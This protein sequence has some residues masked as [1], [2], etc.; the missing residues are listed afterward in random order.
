MV[1][2]G[3]PQTY[4]LGAMVACGL[5]GAFW[6]MRGVWSKYNKKVAIDKDGNLVI[7][8]DVDLA[9]TACYTPSKAYNELH[10]LSTNTSILD[11]HTTS[12]LLEQFLAAPKNLPKA[13]RLTNISLATIPKILGQTANS[14]H[15][16]LEN[17]SYPVHL[18]Q[19]ETSKNSSLTPPTPSIPTDSFLT[20]LLSIAPKITSL[21]ITGGNIQIEK[22]EIKRNPI[23]LQELCVSETSHE[24]V[25]LLLLDNAIQVD[26]L[27]I[28]NNN[29]T[30]LRF[31]DTPTLYTLT[32]LSIISEYAL[33]HIQE[34]S[35]RFLN[36]L[37]HL[38]LCDLSP[39][40]VLPYTKIG[41]SLSLL[42]IE[43]SVVDFMTQLPSLAVD[44]RLFKDLIQA[45]RLNEYNTLPMHAIDVFSGSVKIATLTIRNKA[46]ML[47]VV[48]FTTTLFQVLPTNENTLTDVS[49]A[50]QAPYHGSKSF[51]P[52]FI[53]YLTVLFERLVDLKKLDINLH[54]ASSLDMSGIAHMLSEQLAGLKDVKLRY[55]LSPSNQVYK[56]STQS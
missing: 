53:K 49:V 7:R 26:Q 4:L 44:K 42:T 50:I 11:A 34:R 55:G 28:T 23:Y 33:R 36:T 8:G 5:C 32:R 29:I 18:P 52:E 27:T 25:S 13:I 37:H 45:I 51:M 1:M 10:L 46:H 9:K 39:M 31:L 47:S 56:P 21:S 2:I 17:V 41:T 40:E 54:Y 24:F 14:Y 48:Y 43:A 12:S 38:A 19:S 35:F 30:S 16:Y 20:S 6:F 3:K 15:L 22:G